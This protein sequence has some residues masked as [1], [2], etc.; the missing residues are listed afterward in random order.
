M[1]AALCESAGTTRLL[2][3]THDYFISKMFINGENVLYLMMWNTFLYNLHLSQ[4]SLLQIEEVCLSLTAAFPKDCGPRPHA[5]PRT[6]QSTFPQILTLQKQW[7]TC[8]YRAGM[9]IKGSRL[10]K[11][12]TGMDI[13][14]IQILRD[15]ALFRYS[16]SIHALTLLRTQ[17]HIIRAQLHTNGWEECP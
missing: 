6:N 7:V 14:F 3:S 10:G 15:G 9:E 4:D 11:P 17:P 1:R 5:S 16:L 13:G 2:A 12:A 8:A